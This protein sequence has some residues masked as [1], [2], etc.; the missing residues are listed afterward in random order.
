MPRN[1]KKFPFPALDVNFKLEVLFNMKKEQ[2]Y[3]QHNLCIS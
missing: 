3:H 1:E 2:K